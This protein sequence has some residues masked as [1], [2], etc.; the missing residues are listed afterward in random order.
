MYPSINILTLNRR[1]ASLRAHPPDTPNGRDPARRA[2]PPPRSERGANEGTMEQKRLGRGLQSLISKKTEISEPAETTEL[3]TVSIDRLSPNPRQPRERI[4]NAELERLAASIQKSGILQPIAVRRAGA[5][6]EIIAG[7]RRWRAARLAGLKLVPIVVRDRV[8]DGEM[9]ELA[10]LENVQRVDLNPVEKARG[11]RQLIDEFGKTQDEVARSVGQD[12]STVA[13]LLRLLDLSP[14]IQEAVQRGAL[15]AGHARALL[16]VPEPSKR[17][18]LFERTLRE[19][20]SVREVEFAAAGER[21]EPRQERK[22]KKKAQQPDW[23][24]EL[25]TRWRRRLGTK[26]RILVAGQR[27]KVVIQCGSFDELERVTDLAVGLPQARALE[28]SAD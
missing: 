22:R 14:E 27:S 26:V 15:S 19:D 18:E 17:Q 9:L 2:D 12:R 3:N 16:A 4:E 21:P 11:Y 23:A 13:N 5:K 25:E 7:E 6:L 1:E 8:S 24:D 28:N 20:L 10:L